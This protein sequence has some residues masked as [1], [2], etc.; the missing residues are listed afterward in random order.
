M[1][2]ASGFLHRRWEAAGTE[3]VVSDAGAMGK[4]NRGWISGACVG[5]ALPYVRD[6][7]D[8]AGAAH[9]RTA[10]CVPRGR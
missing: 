6:T 7:K 4:A 1:Q 10:P 2:T 8:D 5:A 3:G 9:A